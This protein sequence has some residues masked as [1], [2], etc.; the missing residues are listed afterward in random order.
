MLIPICIDVAGYDNEQCGPNCPFLDEKHPE[1]R[2]REVNAESLCC[3][4]NVSLEHNRIN[5]PLRC[6]RCCMIEPQE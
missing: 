3:L 4:F 1:S 2:C 6:K 5:L